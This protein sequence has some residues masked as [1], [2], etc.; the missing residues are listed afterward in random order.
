MNRSTRIA[1]LA[2]DGSLDPDRVSDALT[3]GTIHRS[4]DRFLHVLQLGKVRR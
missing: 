3:E 1:D 2:C 4:E